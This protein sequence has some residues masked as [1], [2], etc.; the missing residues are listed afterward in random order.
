MHADL[1]GARHGDRQ[2]RLPRHAARRRAHRRRDGGRRRPGRGAAACDREA[3]AP[4]TVFVSH[5]TYTPGPRG[6]RRGRDPRAAARCSAT[7][8]DAIVIA[9]T[10]G[11]TGHPMG[12]GIEDVLAVK[13]LETG[14]RP[15]G[16]RTSASVDPELGALNLSPRRRVPGPLRAAAGRRVRLA[17]QHDAAALDAGAPTAAGATPTSSGT[18]TGSPTGAAW[19]A[20]CERHERPGRRR[21]SRSS[22]HRL[23]VVD[24][25]PAPR[26]AAAAGSRSPAG[27]RRRARAR[28]GRARRAAS[29]AR[30]GRRA[31]EPAAAPEPEPRR[32]AGGDGV[33]RA[34]WRSWPSRPATRPTCSTWTSTSKPTSGSTPSSRPRCSPTIR[35][36]YGIERDDKLK[37]RDYPTLNHVVGFVHDRAPTAAPARGR[38]RGRAAPVPR[39]PEPRPARGRPRRG[40]AATRCEAGC[41]RSWPSRPATRRTCWTWTSTS[42]PTSGSTRSS[43]PRCSPTIREAYGIE[44]DDTLKLRD[45]PT[46]DHGRRLR[47]RA[48]PPQAAPPRARRRTRAAPT[49]DCSP[50]P[51]ADAFPRRV[52]VPVLRPPL[53]RC[54]A[55]GVGLGGQP[56]V[57][58]LDAAAS[59]RRSS[60]GCTRRGVEV[61]TIDDTPE[62]R[63][64]RLVELERPPTAST[65]CPRSTRGPRR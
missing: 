57:V 27:R 31:P 50:E 32:R 21:G 16:R 17:D 11:F 39:A 9:N 63:R 3:I 56:R 44:R 45:Y 40:G 26:A 20:G 59:P 52:P 28:A 19:T 41:W 60:S 18:P 12:V 5:E 54:A 23:R 43:R 48:R 61:L 6:Q 47:P 10:K 14:D 38:P 36:A 7:A 51:P 25:V 42:R 29:R 2:Q 24:R 22:R 34:C 58:M 62:A 64:S 1:R 33:T 37:L 35:E 55:T 46:L 53:E 8:A 30:A 65:G 13:A 4:E 15:A 49:D